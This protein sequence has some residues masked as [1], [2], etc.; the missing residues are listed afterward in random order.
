MGGRD[1]DIWRERRLRSA[2][3]SHYQ[4]PYSN[5]ENYDLKGRSMNRQL[6]DGA[7]NTF[8]I[9][10]PFYLYQAR[11]SGSQHDKCS[12]YFERVIIE[13]MI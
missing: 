9:E 2:P 3:T 10:R 6:Y 12:S 8:Q 7:R 11:S 1:E 13:P 4:E 5:I